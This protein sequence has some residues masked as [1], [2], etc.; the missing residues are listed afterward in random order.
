MYSESRKSKTKAESGETRGVVSKLP[1]AIMNGVCKITIALAGPESRGRKRKAG[2]IRG[3][4]LT[5]IKAK[6]QEI[7][8]YLISTLAKYVKR[9]DISE[10]NLSESLIRSWSVVVLCMSV[11]FFEDD[12]FYMTHHSPPGEK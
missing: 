6:K 5:F 7:Y 3:I 12:L 2:G 11:M 9:F 10:L 1:T 4:I 8:T